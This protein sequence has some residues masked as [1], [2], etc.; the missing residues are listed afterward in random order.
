MELN[1]LGEEF[2]ELADREL[3]SDQTAIQE[4][5]ARALVTHVLTTLF[6]PTMSW[7]T[8]VEFALLVAQLP[9][10]LAAEDSSAEPDAPV[11]TTEQGERTEPGEQAEPLSPWQ[12]LWDALQKAME[13]N[14]PGEE[15]PEEEPSAEADDSA[16]TD[17]MPPQR[18]TRFDE[19]PLLPRET[20]TAT[21]LTALAA[22]G[23]ATPRRQRRHSP[24]PKAATHHNGR[25][26]DQIM[27]K[28]TRKT[29]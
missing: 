4:A 28:W 23:L 26:I 25:S 19:G 13:E 8:A 3:R 12:Q 21:A 16:A 29:R 15:Q 11:E 9:D 1:E 10:E 6:Q 22:L 20:T 17:N 24:T 14:L 7:M 18:V 5:V 2:V 27:T